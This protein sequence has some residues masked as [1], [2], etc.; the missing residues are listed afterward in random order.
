M[1]AGARI[2]SYGTLDGGHSQEWQGTV[3][4]S[5]PLFTGGARKGERDLSTAE[6]R[7]L[8]EDLRLVEM[9]LQHAVDVAIAAVEEAG[10]LRLALERAARQSEEVARIEALA[11]EAGAGVQ[12]DFL[13][14][15]ADLFQARAA[16]AQARNGEILA[17]IHLARVMGDLTPEWIQ[18]NVEAER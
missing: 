12:T 17:R 9:G 15:E 13:R 10:A 6:E 11:L 5:Y 1:E 2:L 8:A 14:A 16:L 7:R 18:Q 3:R 4:F